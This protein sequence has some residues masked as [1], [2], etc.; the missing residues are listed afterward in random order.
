M[1]W[2]NI[3][4]NKRESYSIEK[5]QTQCCQKS[6]FALWAFIGINGEFHLCYALLNG[7]GVPGSSISEE[8]SS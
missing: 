5:V 6:V 7:G 4:F 8:E 3:K 2:K 1:V